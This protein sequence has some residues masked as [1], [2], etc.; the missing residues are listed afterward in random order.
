MHPTD[1]LTGWQAQQA[2]SRADLLLAA[3]HVVADV[4]AADG[5]RDVEVRADSFVTVQRAAEPADDRPRRRPRRPRPAGA[6]RRVRP[7]ARSADH[8]LTA[9]RRQTGA[10]PTKRVRLFAR[11]RCGRRWWCR[12]LRRP[13]SPSSGWADDDE[14]APV[15]IVSSGGPTFTSLDELVAASDVVVVATVAD[16]ADGR[17]L[18]AAGDPDAGIRTRLVELAVQQTLAGEAGEPLIVEEASQL[19]DGTP[20][21]VDGM[22]PLAEGDQAVWFLVAGGDARGALPRRRQR[23]GPLRRRRRHAAARRR[24]PAEPPAGRA[25]PRRSRRPALLTRGFGG[26]GGVAARRGRRKASGARKPRVG[27]RG[28]RRSVGARGPAARC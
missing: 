2:S 8:R 22:E 24:R 4:A 5:H 3:A 23:A 17:T 18:T 10:M 19:L 9:T 16:V 13:S 7:A 21:V 20:V 1:V 25:R 14:S 11:R 26:T 15:E 6:R 27:I 12:S 28:R